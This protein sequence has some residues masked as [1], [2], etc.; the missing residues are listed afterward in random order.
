MN[1][2]PKFYADSGTSED[3]EHWHRLSEHLHGTGTR[4]AAFLDE[5]GGAD[6]GRVAG[7]LHDLGS[8]HNP[9]ARHGRPQRYG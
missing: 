9:V 6:V 1:A 5:V 8:G 4:V 3:R 7:L 2:P